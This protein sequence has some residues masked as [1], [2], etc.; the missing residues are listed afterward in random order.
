VWLEGL[1]SRFGID[2][3]YDKE[4]YIKLS[5][6]YTLEGFKKATQGYLNSKTSPPASVSI[7]LRD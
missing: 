4:L 1:R 7:M 6:R 2:Q 3:P 5:H